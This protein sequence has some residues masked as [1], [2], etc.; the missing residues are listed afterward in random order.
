MNT[1][2]KT[3]CFFLDL[4][5]YLKV[6]TTLWNIRFQLNIFSYEI[7]EFIIFVYADPEVANNNFINIIFKV[8]KSSSTKMKMKLNFRLLSPPCL[9]K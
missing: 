6:S 8:I 1:I 3:N 7:K 9:V 4:Q 5:F 2:Q